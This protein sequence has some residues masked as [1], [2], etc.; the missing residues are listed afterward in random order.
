MCK[1]EASSQISHRPPLGCRYMIMF[2]CEKDDDSA[3]PFLSLAEEGGVILGSI[4]LSSVCSVSLCPYLH[5]QWSMSTSSV[6]FV[7]FHSLGITCDHLG[8]V[9]LSRGLKYTLL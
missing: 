2:C 7:H 5:C 1:N 6:C 9:V 3:V 8:T 4:W